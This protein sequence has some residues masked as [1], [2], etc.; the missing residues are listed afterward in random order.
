M[1]QAEFRRSMSAGVAFVVL[2]VVGVFVGFGNGPTIKRHDSDATA[3]AKY[4]HTLSSSGHRTGILVGAYLVLLAGLAFVWFSQG[5]RSLVS[6]VAA[7]RLIAALGVLGAAALTAAAMTSAVVAGAV[8]FG[9]E[10]VPHDGDS[11]RVVMDLTFPFIGVVFALVSAA[12]VATIAIRGRVGALP[13]WL[14]YAAWLAVLGAIFAVIFFP[15]LLLLLWY[16]VVA[17]IGVARPAVADTAG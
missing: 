11:I 1:N 9:H 17:I 7:G 12:L 5:L 8:S 13:T 10:P 2:L 15:I 6:T 4:V 3:A 16:L 14:R